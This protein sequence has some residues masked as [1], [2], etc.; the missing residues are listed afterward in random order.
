MSHVH[1]QFL[2]HSPFSYTLTRKP[3][4]VRVTQARKDSSA[5]TDQY[6]SHFVAHF[7]C[8]QSCHLLLFPC[9]CCISTSTPFHSFQ[10]VHSSDS[11][12]ITVYIVT[13]SYSEAVSMFSSWIPRTLTSPRPL[14]TS[15]LTGHL[16]DILNHLRHYVFLVKSEQLFVL[17]IGPAP[18]ASSSLGVFP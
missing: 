7:E 1:L 14:S 15:L 3:I 10:H 9:C 11:S 6:F 5:T 16:A 12:Q 18:F 13:K 4:S 8:Q 17:L 2:K